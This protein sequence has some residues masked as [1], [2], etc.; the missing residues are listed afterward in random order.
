MA[1]FKNQAV[2]VRKE[3][4]SFIFRT[5]KHQV[6]KRNLTFRVYGEK[7]LGEDYGMGFGKAL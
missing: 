7:D 6:Q 4:P 3:Q 2:R 5:W 1:S